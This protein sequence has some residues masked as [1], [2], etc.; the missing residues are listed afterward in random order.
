MT[1]KT[2]SYLTQLSITFILFI[3]VERQTIVKI[4]PF[5]SRINE[6]SEIFK[7]VSMIRKYHNHTPQTIPWHREEVPLNHNVTPGRQIKQSIQLSLPKQDDCNTRMNI[8]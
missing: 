3:N 8:K 7:N 6:L 2:I 1:L 5:M 4:L